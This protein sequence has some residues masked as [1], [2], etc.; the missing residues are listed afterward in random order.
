MPHWAS[1]PLATPHTRPHKGIIAGW[2]WDG[3]AWGNHLK[4]VATK[5]WTQ[6]FCAEVF[7]N[8]LPDQW[9]TVTE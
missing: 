4:E 2:G 5:I 6:E 8:E 1:R 9:H 7:Q 3:A